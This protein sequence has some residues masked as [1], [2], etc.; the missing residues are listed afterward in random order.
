L[1]KRIALDVSE[2]ST[3]MWPVANRSAMGSDTD[4]KYRDGRA[5]GCI[6]TQHTTARLRM[7]T[8][9]AKRAPRTHQ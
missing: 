1:S 7:L 9:T 2:R 5:C 6:G 4:D 3:I 8:L